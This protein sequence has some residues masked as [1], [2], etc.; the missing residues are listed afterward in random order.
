MLSPTVVPSTIATTQI[1]Q[2]FRTVIVSVPQWCTNSLILYYIIYPSQTTLSQLHCS[3]TAVPIGQE[4]LGSFSRY[5]S[6]HLTHSS[7]AKIHNVHMGVRNGRFTKVLIQY[8]LYLYL[9]Y[10]CSIKLNFTE[11]KYGSY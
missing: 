7:C 5:G 2:L 8:T 6:K 4:F 3:F 1:H 10:I 9:H 11:I